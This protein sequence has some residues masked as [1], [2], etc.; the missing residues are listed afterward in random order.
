[1]NERV[2]KFLL[3]GDNFM[4]K[5]HLREPG[6][7][8]SACGPFTTNKQRIQNFQETGDSQYVTCCGKRDQPLLNAIS[9]RS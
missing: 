4:L 3:A 9:K 7:I 2:N 5:I 8:H 1:M 6:F